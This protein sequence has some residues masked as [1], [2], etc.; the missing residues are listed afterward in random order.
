M[1]AVCFSKCVLIFWFYVSKNKITAVGITA[2]QMPAIVRFKI[3]EKVSAD[4]LKRAEKRLRMDMKGRRSRALTK[5][6]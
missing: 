2:I 5:S 3:M 4:L 1:I 6:M